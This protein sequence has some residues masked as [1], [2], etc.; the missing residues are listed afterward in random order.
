LTR[1]LKHLAIAGLALPVS[2]VG[3]HALAGRSPGVGDPTDAPRALVD[4]VQGLALGRHYELSD[5]ELLERNLY[6]VEHRYVE[7]DRLDAEAMFQGALDG[8]EREVNEV[9]FIREPGGRRLQVSVGAWT[10]V[11][12]VDPITSFDAFY[13]Q[14]RR[15]AAVLEDRL[16]EDV[17]HED[18]EYALINGALSTLDP[19]TMLL[20]PDAAREMEVDN[21]G[22]FGGL[23][24][25]IFVNR[26][27]RLVV[28]KPF[29]G[30]PADKAGLLANDQI[31]R[32]E[33]ESAINMDLDEAVTRL[34]GE[35]GTSVTLKVR[36]EGA[37]G[38]VDLRSYTLTRARIEIFKVEGELLEGG[39]G[40]VR[41]P[42]FHRNVS[43]NLDEL[44]TRFKRESD[45]HLN[46]LVLDLRDNPGGYLN[47]AFEV[48]NR[49]LTDGVV[50]ATVEGGSRRREEQRATRP[51]TEP[52]YPIVVLVNGSSASASEIVAGAL[53]N[54]DRA[55]I[56]GERT[57]GKGSVQ[58]LY[59]NKDESQLKLT[60]AKYLTPGDHSIQSIG[61][62]P[63]ILLQPAVVREPEEPGDD[64]LVSL[65]WREWI[66]RE[67]DLDQ[68][69]AQMDRELEPP[70]WKVRYLRPA[71]DSAARNGDAPDARQDW[72]V[73]FS[74]RVLLASTSSRRAEV[75]RAA[76]GVVEGAR[77]QQ[78]LAV[79]DAF[80]T[81][82]V[83]WADGLN[84]MHP[85]LDVRVDLGEDGVLMAGE[86]E[87]MRLVVRNDGTDALHRTT[88]VTESENPWLDHLEFTLGRLEAGETREL[89]HLVDLHDGYSDE[90]S[91]FS[92]HFR[93]QDGA[94]I[95]TVERSVETQARPRPLFA[96]SLQVIDDGSGG[97]E[98]DADGVPEAGEIIELELTVENIG[99]GASTQGFARVRNRSGRALDLA[100]GRVMLGAAQD[101]DGAACDL[102]Q[103]DGCR[104]RLAP[105]DVS[106]QRFNFTLRELTQGEEA[107]ALQLEIGDNVGYDYAAIHQ[108]G[109]PDYFQLTEDLRF[110]PEAPLETHQ[111]RPPKIRV[112]RTLPL[113]SSDPHAVLSGVVEDDESVRDIMIYHGQDKVFYQGGHADSQ[114]IPFTVE[115]TLEAGGNLITILARDARGL[116]TTW[117]RSIWLDAPERTAMATEL[118]GDDDMGGT[119]GTPVTP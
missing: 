112:T 41:I 62:P 17:E 53:R 71:R 117:S 3:Y 31:V 9:M 50:V 70:A 103:D 109:F 28:K 100:R 99:D 6:H 23:G 116:R 8:V 77:R 80:R 64:P 88:I 48:A 97:S 32:I 73:D 19:H 67:A 34:R 82:G 86:P 118:E 59:R 108:G 68:H 12:L 102:D 90:V 101:K 7:K 16:S 105:G 75:L 22:E 92:L 46:G 74:R 4:A 42:T 45:G 40:Y 65:F 113:R 44:L 26:D 85:A 107:W 60:V 119:P 39:V 18:V 72:E 10:T 25:E 43:A 69:L 20:P 27:G 81:I 110:G 61:I 58:H 11:L 29:E 104:T 30:T 5:L 55:V 111:R 56:I 78:E 106:V 83:E 54:R 47:Q 1:V 98:G 13:S 57:F 63:D 91:P 14:L 24:V 96:Y 36:R 115:P 84:V 51:G 93:D 15:V 76:H 49:F 37:N 87:L 89:T 66:D 79:V 35:V 38:D 114:A 95:A 94:E 52:D 2:L 33:D 21:Q